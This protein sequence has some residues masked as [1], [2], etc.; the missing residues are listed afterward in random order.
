M[1]LREFVRRVQGFDT[2]SHREKIKHFAWWLH[3][4]GKRERFDVAAIRDCYSTVDMQPSPNLSQELTRLEARRPRELLTDGGGYRLE[5]TSRK[6]LNDKYGEAE[7]IIVVTKLLNDLVG[8]VSDQSEQLFLS[9]ALICYKHRA[10]RAAIVM[11][12]NL[13]YDHVLNWLLSDPQRL[14]SFNGSIAGR[15]GPKRG[16]GMIIA[17]REEFEELREGEVLDICGKAGVL[18]SKNIKQI[19]DAQ[20]DKRNMAAHPSLVDISE[21]EANETIHMLVSNVV[22][23]LE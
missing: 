10:F 12:W 18:P 21:P 20:L 6:A 5:A 15:I 22:L 1:E 17:K 14:S 7:V 16:A 13:A 4:H 23:R 2:R 3:T 8:K 9:E 19:L 11:T